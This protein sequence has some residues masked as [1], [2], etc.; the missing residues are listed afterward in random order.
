[1]SEIY[2]IKGERLFPGDPDWP[3]GP[4]PDVCYQP[5]TGGVWWSRNAF[6][7]MRHPGR[8]GFNGPKTPTGWPDSTGAE[9][10]AIL[11]GEVEK[12]KWYDN[13]LWVRIRHTDDLISLSGHLNAPDVKTGD[14]V[15]LGQRLS[16]LW[17][18]VNPAH[19]HNQ[20]KVRVDGKWLWVDPQIWYKANGAVAK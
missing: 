15:E 3:F 13:G 8:D 4:V 12:A 14:T 20:I 18:G 11:P 7:P 2:V 19:L 5:I 16:S 10:I 6:D 17:G 9:V 1:M